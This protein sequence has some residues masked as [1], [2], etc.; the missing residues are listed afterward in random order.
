MPILTPDYTHNL[1]KKTI[2][3]LIFERDDSSNFALL[4]LIEYKRE[5]YV[6]II[7]N[8]TDT[9]VSAFILNLAKPEIIN[10]DDLLRFAVRW[11]YTNSTNYP[12]SIEFAKLG[13]SQRIEHIY[14]TFDINFVSRIVGSPFTFD[15]FNATAKTKRRK[16]TPITNYEEVTFQHL[17]PT[18]E[19]EE[20]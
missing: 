19:A 12:L 13:L 15:S 1:I 9:E 16:V 3:P 10:Q 17:H 20:Q 6:G 14:R 5:N 7:D 8:I 18:N 11:L 4:S 2:P